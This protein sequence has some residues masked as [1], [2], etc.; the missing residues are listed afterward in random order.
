MKELYLDYLKTARKLHCYIAKLKEKRA[1]LRDVDEIKSM[2]KRI[3]VLSAE[4]GELIRDAGMIK[5]YLTE[6]EINEITSSD[7]GDVC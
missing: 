6:D 3:E 2:N 1:L 4:Y 5:K 7:L